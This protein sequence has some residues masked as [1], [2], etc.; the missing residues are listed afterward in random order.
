[1]DKFSSTREERRQLE[2]LLSKAV[3][4][5]CQKSVTFDHSLTVEGLVGITVDDGHV[6]LLSVNQVIHPK[7]CY[8]PASAPPDLEKD[9]IGETLLNS[10]LPCSTS[11]VKSHY[12]G[13]AETDN[14]IVDVISPQTTDI[15]PGVA[16]VIAK[17]KGEVKWGSGSSESSTM[18]HEAKCE[19]SALNR[20]LNAANNLLLPGGQQEI[21]VNSKGINFKTGSARRKHPYPMHVVP[22]VLDRPK[23]RN[24]SQESEALKPQRN[25]MNMSGKKLFHCKFCSKQFTNRG[26]LWRHQLTHE[27]AK[28]ESQHCWICGLAFP[29]HSGDDVL[30]AHM[31]EKHLCSLQSPDKTRATTVKVELPDMVS[32]PIRAESCTYESAATQ[33]HLESE[34]VIS[35]KPVSSIENGAQMQLI[36]FHKSLGFRASA[37]ST[38][39]IV[40]KMGKQRMYICLVCHKKFMNR[41]SLW[42]HSVNK[43]PTSHAGHGSNLTLA[44]ASRTPLTSA[45]TQVG[46]LGMECSEAWHPHDNEVK[47]NYSFT[48]GAALPLVSARNDLPKKQERNSL[49]VE[50]DIEM[51]NRK[52]SIPSSSCD[53]H[54]VDSNMNIKVKTL[55]SGAN[56]ETT[57]Y[58]CDKSKDNSAV[59]ETRFRPVDVKHDRSNECSISEPINLTMV[60]FQDFKDKEDNHYHQHSPI[61]DDN[62]GERQS[63]SRNS[64]AKEPHDSVANFT[65]TEHSQFLSCPEDRCLSTPGE[66]HGTVRTEV[67]DE[68]LE[69]MAHPKIS[70]LSNYGT[71]ITV[72]DQKYYRC[73]E[74]SKTFRNR[75]S[76]WRHH[77]KHSN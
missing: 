28:E 58:I 40:T 45:N 25:A 70:T 54:Q 44:A 18:L 65:N 7:P 74:C 34:Y 56:M 9:Y 39:G 43:H 71:V 73:N 57:S 53:D 10:G 11:E 22:N 12:Q 16:M 5:L 47:G 37:V 14:T 72:G 61:S 55:F 23:E 36:N 63:R 6:I 69:D 49:E 68:K 76:L 59:F 46:A 52:A 27:E 60:N 66:L 8:I 29:L 3:L 31:Q 48:A 30:Q 4:R 42:R 64:E 41:S 33:P 77:F 17:T 2:G 32:N 75:V 19:Q 38:Y 15:E 51:T 1:M 35:S 62:N 26:S 13:R 50:P 21:Q 67:K 24:G 20:D